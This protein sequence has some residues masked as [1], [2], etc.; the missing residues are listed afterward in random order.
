M[1]LNDWRLAHAPA[2][3]WLQSACCRMAREVQGTSHGRVL[4][5]CSSSEAKPDLLLTRIICVRQ[6]AQGHAAAWG[7]CPWGDQRSAWHCWADPSPSSATGS[8]CFQNFTDEFCSLTWTVPGQCN[9][10]LILPWACWKAQTPSVI[11]CTEVSYVL[12]D[13][14]PKTEE[15]G[16]RH[17]CPNKWRLLVVIDRFCLTAKGETLMILYVKL[18]RT[19]QG[20]LGQSVF[21]LREEKATKSIQFREEK[22][23]NTEKQIHSSFIKP[24]S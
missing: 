20:G 19:N 2:T 7:H 12:S 5:S 17:F 4:L 8:R 11:L 15:K 24:W 23:Q 16:L 14:P 3:G 6:C 21:L 10:V 18:S 22:R 1:P 13:S 9:K